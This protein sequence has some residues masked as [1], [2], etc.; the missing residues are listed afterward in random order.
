MQHCVFSSALYHHF[1][2]RKRRGM[3]L[4]TT[5]SA[6]KQCRVTLQNLCSYGLSGAQSFSCVTPN[7]QVVKSH[8]FLWNCNVRIS[9]I[10]V[11][12]RGVAHSG[13]HRGMYV[14]W[15]RCLKNAQDI[16]ILLRSFQWLCFWSHKAW[17][18]SLLVHFYRKRL[19]SNF[20]LW[21]IFGNLT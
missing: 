2:P 17:I 10:T 15:I 16:N 7:K 1:F 18:E 4:M 20:G 21:V 11:T 8:L 19:V 12:A 3:K 5:L 13:T 9:I 14:D 6:E